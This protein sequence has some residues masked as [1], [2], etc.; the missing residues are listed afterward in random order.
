MANFLFAPEATAVPNFHYLTGIT[1]KTCLIRD[2][3]GW[4]LS[5][6]RMRERSSEKSRCEGIKDTSMECRAW[7]SWQTLRLGYRYGYF[8]SLSK[9]PHKA[10]NFLLRSLPTY[11]IMISGIYMI[12]CQAKE[13]RQAS[14]P[15]Y[16]THSWA[17]TCLACI[18]GS[19]ELAKLDL[20]SAANDYPP[21]YHLPGLPPLNS[22]SSPLSKIK[23]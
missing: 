16:N 9:H 2:R 14:K 22:Q 8:G 1:A 11:S 13:K 23:K 4:V 15:L 3:N 17:S 7:E 5:G 18:S 20:L 12:S 10:D 19:G 6:W 21:F